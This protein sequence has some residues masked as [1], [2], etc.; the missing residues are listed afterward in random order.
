VILHL[1]ASQVDDAGNAGRDLLIEWAGVDVQKQM[2][3]RGSWA[4]VGS[5]C[6]L[7]A[8]GGK[9]HMHSGATN[10]VAC[11]GSVDIHAGT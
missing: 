5:G 10:S 9:G 4:L 2:M 1:R 11:A 7:H 6:Q 3:V 8:A